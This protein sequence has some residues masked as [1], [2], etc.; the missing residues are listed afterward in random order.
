MPMRGEVLP[1]RRHGGDERLHVVVLEEPAGS[2]GEWTGTPL[3]ERDPDAAQ[4]WHPEPEADP[5]EPSRVDEACTICADRFRDMDEG[6]L[7]L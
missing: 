2:N 5:N 6:G 3:C 7:V 1:A 4:P